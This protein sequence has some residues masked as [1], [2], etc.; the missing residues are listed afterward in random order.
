MISKPKCPTNS[1]LT[2]L[3][4]CGYYEPRGGPRARVWLC[5]CGLCGETTRVRTALLTNG[6]TR[7]CGCLHSSTITTHGCSKTPEFRC[8]QNILQRCYNSNNQQY[9]NYGSRGVRVSPRWLGADGF[10]RFLSDMGT[11]P[12]KQHSIERKDVNGNY[13]PYNCVW[14]TAK[15]QARNRRNSVSLTIDGVTLCLAEWVERYH[16]KYTTVHERLRRGW[17]PLESLTGRRS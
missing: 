8:W 13:G 9:S 1:F 15:V 5:R 3:R 4:P 16:L 17:T 12:S 10:K 6:N 14:A 7:S 11:R 2:P